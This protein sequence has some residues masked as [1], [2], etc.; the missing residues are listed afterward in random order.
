MEKKPNTVKAIKDYRVKNERFRWITQGK[1]TSN[2]IKKLTKAI[3]EAENFNCYEFNTIFLTLIVSDRYSTSK[4]IERIRNLTI[5]KDIKNEIIADLNDN[6][7]CW[8]T[9]IYSFEHFLTEKSDIEAIHRLLKKMIYLENKKELDNS[10]KDFIKKEIK[11]LQSGIMSPIF[12]CLRPGIYPII[13]GPASTALSELCDVKITTKLSNYLDE[14]EFFVKLKETY[15]FD[16]DY[17]DIDTF[18]Y[19]RLREAKESGEELPIDESNP[20]FSAIFTPVDL[21]VTLRKYI[22]KNPEVLEDGLELIYEDV[23]ISNDSNAR[24]DLVFRK[25]NGNILIVETKRD[26]G[27]RDVI[28]QIHDYIGAA[29]K[30]F[31]ITRDEIEGLVVCYKDRVDQSLENAI[32]ATDKIENI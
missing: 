16:D 25:R 32:L 31:N 1:E 14:R 22:S 12:Y 10:I 30:E 21:E 26:R 3:I 7:G 24:P 13:N 8:G 2:V 23:P 6:I 19:M 17:R 5:V 20:E 4:K 11:G 27:S 29:M 15:D 28:G 9:G 18:L